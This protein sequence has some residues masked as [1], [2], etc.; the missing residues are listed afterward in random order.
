MSDLLY[1]LDQDAVGEVETY[2]EAR[3]LIEAERL[4]ATIKEKRDSIVRLK[5]MLEMVNMRGQAL[6]QDKEEK[7]AKATNA[8]RPFVAGLVATNIEH[9]P[10]GKKSVD[11]LAGSAGFR[12]GRTSIDIKDPDKALESC[13]K[14]GIE[15]IVKESVSKTAVKGFIDKGN[16]APEGTEVV[17]GEETFTVKTI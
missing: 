5:Q 7:I 4:V 15:T 16:P 3:E 6:I 10:S 9:N 12:K 13:H 11:F 2:N 17:E 14:L 8:L 1:L